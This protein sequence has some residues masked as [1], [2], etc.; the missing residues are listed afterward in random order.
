MFFDENA[1]ILLDRA[2][3]S[4]LIMKININSCSVVLL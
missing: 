2:L 3:P 4:V 1:W